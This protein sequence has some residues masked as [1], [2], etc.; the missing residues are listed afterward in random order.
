MFKVIIIDHE[1]KQDSGFGLEL[2]QEI[3]FRYSAHRHN[4][5]HLMSTL[6]RQMSAALLTQA[7]L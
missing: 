1:Y 3:Y 4:L 7:P 5:L 2:I 6:I